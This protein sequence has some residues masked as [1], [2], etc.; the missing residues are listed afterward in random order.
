[1]GEALLRLAAPGKERISDCA[2]FEKWVG[3]SELNVVA[4]AARLGLDTGFITK[5]PKNEIGELIRGKM[6]FYGVDDRLV[7]EDTHRNARLGIYYYE[8]GASPRKP[9]VV[10]DR[11]NSS[12]A[13]IKLDDIP[14]NI[15]V[16]SI[17]FHTCGITLALG[18]NVRHTVVEL[19][20][21][22]RTAGSLISFDVNYRAN[23]TSEED[24]REA[25]EEILPLID[26]LFVSEESS[27]KMFRK[28]GDLRSIMKSYSEEYGVKVVSTT[29]RK[30]LQ[31]GRQSFG[32][33]IYSRDNDAYYTEEPYDNIE[34]V[35]RIGSGDAYVAGVIAAY[36]KYR[37]FRKAVEFG[38]AMA[39]LKNTICGDQTGSDLGEVI[40]LI[41]ERKTGGAQQ[42]MNR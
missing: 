34:I 38:D 15:D 1:L 7:V 32:S 24:A 30:I 4:A 11:S 16:K 35:D 13:G 37:D 33:V 41:E 26:F 3:G 9:C 18:E 31:N 6:R 14:S 28:T 8:N 42:E 12:F 17:V 19:I 10:Y 20:K 2:C 22:F 23:L 40:R 36:L 5:L 27:R 21:R 39:V 29:M 25:I